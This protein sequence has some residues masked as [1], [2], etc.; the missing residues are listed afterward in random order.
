MKIATQHI[1]TKK[2][3]MLIK[4]KSYIILA[5]QKYLFKKCPGMKNKQ[6]SIHNVYDVTG[7]GLLVRTRTT[8]EMAQ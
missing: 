1:Y 7:T 3:L 2:Q 4:S 5:L 8:G 6:L